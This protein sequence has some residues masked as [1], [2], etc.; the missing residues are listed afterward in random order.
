MKT[1]LM[2]ITPLATILFNIVTDIFAIVIER[3]KIDGKIEGVVPHLVDGYATILF[4]E[5]DLMKVTNLKLILS[6]FE[7]KLQ[8]NFHKN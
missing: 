1:E 4:T 6:T 3:A 5:H 8:I 7:I 2:Q